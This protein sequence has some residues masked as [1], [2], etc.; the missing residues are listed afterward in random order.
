ML[1]KTRLKS[2]TELSSFKMLAAS[3]LLV[4]TTTVSKAIAMSVAFA[5]SLLLAEAVVVLC[6]K[7]IPVKLRSLL[8]V[9]VTAFSASVT[10][11]LVRYF[12]PTTADALG[13]YLPIL[14]V[15]CIILIQLESTK[16]DESAGV[17]L[18]SSL[19]TCVQML[20]VMVV[21]AIPREVLGLGKLFANVHEKGGLQIFETAPLPILS[22]TSGLLIFVGI[23]AALAKLITKSVSKRAPVNDEM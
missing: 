6:K 14:A 17:A 11:I 8:F 23:A 13:V 16:A 22:Q 21:I 15:S 3:P 4:V 20:L 12:F 2:S 10:E 9:T 1:I 7:H 5:I 19:V 18:F